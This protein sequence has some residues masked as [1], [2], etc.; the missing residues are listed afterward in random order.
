M[1]LLTG[2]Q[3]KPIVLSKAIVYIPLNERWP[4]GMAKSGL[5]SYNSL[6]G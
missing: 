1:V 2:S 5:I 4:E 3:I 6:S